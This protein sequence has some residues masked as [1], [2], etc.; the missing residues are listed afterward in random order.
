MP[1]YT[2]TYTK[3]SQGP[4][5]QSGGFH[6]MKGTNCHFLIIQIVT[7]AVHFFLLTEP[8]QVCSHTF[9]RSAYMQH[10]LSCH[11]VLVGCWEFHLCVVFLHWGYSECSLWCIFNGI[12]AN[13][14]QGL[15]L[16]LCIKYLEVVFRIWAVL[17]WL[18]IPIIWSGVYSLSTENSPRWW[19]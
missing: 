17:D 1:V 10:H 15:L 19:N 5:T 13:I 18:N 3:I 12:S 9:A 14:I 6:W 16:C 4:S 7:N 11:P 2:R 8:S